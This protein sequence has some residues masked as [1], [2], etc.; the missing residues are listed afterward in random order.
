MFHQVLRGLQGGPGWFLRRFHKGSVPPLLHQVQSSAL[1]GP[2]GTLRG[3]LVSWNLTSNLAEP[4]GIWWNV[5]GTRAGGTLVE[6]WWNLA[7]PWWNPGRTLVE[8][9]LKPPRT[10]PQPSQ[11]LGTLVE[12]SWNLTSNH[13]RPSRSPCRTWWNPVWNP[14]LVEP[15]IKPPRNT[16]QNLVEPPQTTRDHPAALAEPGGTLVE[17]SWNLTSN[18]PR[19]SQNPCVEPSSRGTLHQTTT[20]QNG[21]LV[22]PWWNP[23]GTLVEPWWNPGG[24]LVEPCL[25]PPQITPL[26]SQNLVEPWWN[27]GGTLPQTTPD[28]PAALAEPG[29]TL[30]EPWWNLGGTLVEPSWNLTSNHPGPPRSPRRTW[31]NSGGTLVEPSWNLTSGLPRTTPDPIWAETPK[32]SAVGETKERMQ[33]KRPSCIR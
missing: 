15:Y 5:G 3:T 31:W 13:P 9:C 22:E 1:A 21:T 4:G 27:P 32:L 19:L 2:G 17:L 10:T 7:E 24:T 18:H 12:L 26:P 28:H 14:R 20:S 16:S 11:N 8:P 30:V 23:G 29:G 6:P 25:K 33:S